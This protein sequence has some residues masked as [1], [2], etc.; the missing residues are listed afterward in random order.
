MSDAQVDAR[1]SGGL[2]PGSAEFRTAF[3]EAPPGRR[4]TLL[5][6]ADWADTLEQENLVKLS[7]FRGKAGITTLLPPGSPECMNSAAR[8]HPFRWMEI[9]QVRSAGS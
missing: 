9:S 4:D 8:R 6:L 5:P 2:S 7:A 1:Q 3:A